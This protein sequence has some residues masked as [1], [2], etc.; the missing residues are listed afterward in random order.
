MTLDWPILVI[1]AVLLVLSAFFS[2]SET[3]LMSL[4]EMKI[5]KLKNKKSR[6]R[7]RILLRRSSVLLITVLFGGITVNTAAASVLERLFDIKSLFLSTVV[8]T[9]VILLIGEI[10]PNIVAILR[11]EKIAVFNSR[12][13]YPFYLLILPVSRLLDKFINF[14]PDVIKKARMDEG[15]DEEV[16]HLSALMSI[17]SREGIF[18]REEKKLIGS[19]LNFAGREVWNIMTPRISLVSIDKNAP[20]KD[21]VKLIKKTKHSKLPVY[22]NTDD[23]IVGVVHLKDIFPYAHNPD[24]T[25]DKKAGDIMAPMYF[26][27]E[28]KKLSEMLNDFKNKK[29]RVAAVVDEYGSALGIVTIAD[30]L[31]EIVGEL[32]DESFTLVNKIIRISQKRFLVNGDVSLDDFNRTFGTSLAS[33]EYETLAGFIIQTAG[34]IPDEG[35]ST[36]VGKYRILLKEKSDKHIEKFIVEEI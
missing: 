5:N 19:V 14:L 23:N 13:L 9:S 27:P 36:Q 26:V 34:D 21:V 32:M 6:R 7:I 17:V 4:D 28:S 35:Y 30:V 18:S 31:G 24:K 25:S 10:A 1:S 3:A 8:V 12:I 29:I 20:V 33:T 15:E 22:D 2:S 11:T 16:D